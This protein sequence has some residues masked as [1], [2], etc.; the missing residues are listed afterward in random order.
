MT[1]YS[2]MGG[3]TD[4][5]SM[6]LR[7]AGDPALPTVVSLVTEIKGLTSSSSSSSS[8]VP[9]GPGIGLSKIVTPLRGFVAYKKHPWIAPA[10]IGG[11]VLIIFSLGV[12]AGRAKQRRRTP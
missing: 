5:A 9:S 4:V 7:V 12:A 10:L 6:A 2:G 8:S 1:Y 3:V 11:T